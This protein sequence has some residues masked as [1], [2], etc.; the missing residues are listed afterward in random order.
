MKNSLFIIGT[1]TDCG[2]TVV[3]AG[4]AA[5]LRQAD[6]DVGVYKP[7][8]AACTDSSLLKTASGSPDAPEEINPYH[9]DEPLAPGVAARRAGVAI[10]WNHVIDTFRELQAR[11]QILLAEGA[12]GLMVP[13]DGN[14]THIELLRDLDVPV[15][16]VARLGLGT[17]NHTLLTVKVL[18]DN[19]IRCR[20]VILNEQTPRSSIAEET[21][22]DVLSEL[23]PV[24]LLGIFAHV[25]DVSDPAQL[26]AAVPNQLKE[27][28]LKFRRGR[29]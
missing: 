13:L 5:S 2:K 7:F 12:G 1:D 28:F 21:N 26:A 25:Q 20:G 3:T 24:P 14:K 11:H 8:E 29:S 27:I 19:A 15:L 22:Y 6:R 16:I 10:D 4:I 9:F 17:L 18:Q 23:C